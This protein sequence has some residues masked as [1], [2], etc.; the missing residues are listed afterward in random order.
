MNFKSWIHHF[1]NTLAKG[2]F[3]KNQMFSVKINLSPADD[4]VERYRLDQPVIASCYK[5]LKRD[6]KNRFTGENLEYKY[7]S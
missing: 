5:T 4:F 6:L 1:E 3:E 2:R 7:Q